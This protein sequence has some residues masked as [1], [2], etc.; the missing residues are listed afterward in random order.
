MAGCFPEKLSRCVIDE[1]CQGSKMLN[2]LSSP[3][4]Q[5][6]RY[7]RT[8]LCVCYATMSKTCCH[9]ANGS[10]TIKYSCW[11]QMTR[12]HMADCWRR[13]VVNKKKQL[14]S[15]HVVVSL[16]WT[17]VTTRNEIVWTEPEHLHDAKSEW[18]DREGNNCGVVL[19]FLR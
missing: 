17:V 3:D 7:I 14:E 18:R 12:Q 5:I 15:S 13:S 16:L 9:L 6:L 10:A 2:L 4:Y 1:V 11:L 19:T 8:N